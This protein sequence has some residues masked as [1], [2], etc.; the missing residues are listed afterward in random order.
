LARATT[1]GSTQQATNQPRRTV[2]IVGKRH[3]TRFY[4][5]SDQSDLTDTRSASEQA[6]LTDARNGSPKNVTVVDGGATE[7]RTWDFFRQAHT[8]LG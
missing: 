7:A 5:P 2:I 1:L 4:P 6:D 8:G 3:H